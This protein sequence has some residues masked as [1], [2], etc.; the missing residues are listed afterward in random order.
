MPRTE[1]RSEQLK[2]KSILIADL[3]DFAA[4]KRATT[5]IV[6]INAGTVRN[7]NVITTQ[8]AQTITVADSTTNYL[9]IDNTGIIFSNT[10]GFT[11]GRVPIAIAVASGGNVTTVTDKRTWVTAI[12]TATTPQSFT[13]FT[14]GLMGA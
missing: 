12:S 8:T 2:D 9:E 10:T 6:D 1:V 14:A 7:D 11:S 4:T 13:A 3:A 5:L